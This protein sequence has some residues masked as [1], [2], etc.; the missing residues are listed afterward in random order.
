M[1]AN[2]E[3]RKVVIVADRYLFEIWR[4][5][6][7]VPEENMP[8]ER[9]VSGIFKNAELRFLVRSFWHVRVKNQ[10]TCYVAVKYVSED[11]SHHMTIMHQVEIFPRQKFPNDY[12]DLEPSN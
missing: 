9:W 6:Y 7:R 2:P 1:S 12:V 4:K 5:A 11:G 10:R 3:E 8:Y